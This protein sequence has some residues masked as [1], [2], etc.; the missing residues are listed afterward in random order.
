MI[1]I[2]LL[3]SIYRHFLELMTMVDGARITTAASAMSRNRGVRMWYFV[4]VT[5][6]LVKLQGRRGHIGI[7]L[8][9]TL[10]FMLE[11]RAPISNPQ[12][13]ILIYCPNTKHEGCRINVV[14]SAVVNVKPREQKSQYAQ[15][16]PGVL[17]LSFED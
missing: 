5:L 6:I 11:W 10:I 15:V 14:T 16:G 12:V 9:R 8:Q 17:A 13:K 2:R 7:I 4:G 1:F 3:L